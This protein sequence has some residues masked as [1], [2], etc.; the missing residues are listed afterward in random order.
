M[1]KNKILISREFYLLIR[2]MQIWFLKYKDKMKGEYDIIFVNVFE[3]VYIIVFMS[4]VLYMFV[5]I[6][7]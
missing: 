2:K 7:F 5:F 4:I 3:I 1:I 6:F